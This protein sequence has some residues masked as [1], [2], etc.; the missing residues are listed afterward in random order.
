MV[1]PPVDDR[2]AA[3]PRSQHRRRWWQLLVAALVIVVAVLSLIYSLQY[4]D[5]AGSDADTRPAVTTRVG[6]FRG[7]DVDGVKEFGTWLGREVEYVVDFSGRADWQQIS[8]PQ[9]LID[10][11]APTPYR[12]VYSLA[13]LPQNEADTIERGATGEYD[14]YYRELARRLVAAGQEDSILR[15]G[16]EF[17][18]EDSRWSTPNSAAFIDYFRHVVTAMRA[19]PGQKFQFDWNPNNGNGKYDA[20]N[21]YPG[22]DVVDYIG[23]DAY[24]TSWD[25]GAY[26]YPPDC[27]PACR[28]E[29]QK[30]AWDNSV[31]GGPRGLKFWSQFAAD[32]GKPMSLPEWGNWER[33]DGHGGGE[34]PDY[35][36][37][38]HTFINDPGNRI[39]YHAYF[40]FDGP[41][42]PHRL[43]TTNPRAGQVFRDLFG[44]P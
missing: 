5:P 17:N 24:D 32:H 38:M 15:L 31:Y 28:S 13:L 8:E 29:R 6:V 26:P 10:T 44:S 18:L 3:R 16:W 41:D 27:D 42:G 30:T 39:A 35:I 4:P 20:V 7:T 1:H 34:N 33:Q 22:D 14:H 2:P 21:Y 12:T 36:R 37:R 25:S 40:E 43:M 23:I 9:N 19:E 11:W